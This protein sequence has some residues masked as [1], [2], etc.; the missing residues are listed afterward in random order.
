M[1][2]ARLRRVRPV[3]PANGPSPVRK[4]L[5]RH[6]RP[7]AARVAAPACPR[8][9]SAAQPRWFPPP[10]ERFRVS[11][12]D[13]LQGPWLVAPGRPRRGARIAGSRTERRIASRRRSPSS[14]AE[15]RQ[16][17]NPGLEAL[18]VRSV[19]RRDRR[20]SDD[21]PTRGAAPGATRPARGPSSAG[22][23]GSGLARGCA[24]ATRSAARLA[25]PVARDAGEERRQ[26]PG[27][28]PASGWRRGG[29]APK[30]RRR[31]P[32]DACLSRRGPLG[33]ERRQ[34]PRRLTPPPRRVSHS[35][36]RSR[37]RANL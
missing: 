18:D 37:I 32:R 24:G 19:E 28:S 22:S 10:A 33:E 17:V 16:C 14:E 36:C 2:A 20:L 25:R 4:T 23:P 26:D 13:R 21:G 29:G 9:P 15:G 7:L 8:Q 6:W 27:A 30:V 3:A 12:P 1:P 35:P 31:V 5:R 34:D 11:V